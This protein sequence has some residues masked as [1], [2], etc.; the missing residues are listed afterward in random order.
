MIHQAAAALAKGAP[1]LVDGQKTDGIESALRDLRT[2]CPIDVV[3][4]RAHGRA[5]AFASPG[6]E[7]FADWQARPHEA[8]PGFVTLPGVFSADGPDPGSALLAR[9]LP[10]DLKGRA[11]DLGA[12][13]GWLAAQALTRPGLREL[14]LVEAEADALDCARRNVTDPRARFH[15]A[16]ATAFDPGHRFDVVLMN[17]PFHPA[18]AADP[19]LG[20]AFIHAARRLL[21]PPGILWMVA[22]RTLPYEEALARD[23]LEHQTIALEG[24]FKVIRA[25]KPRRAKA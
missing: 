25:A 20:A 17:P 7:A 24:G 6:A 4:S 23:F 3:V 11:A 9:H 18:R 8:V 22:N 10:A 13:W 12:G 21:H 2:R 16:D 15:W 5:F 19:A 14:H 1:I